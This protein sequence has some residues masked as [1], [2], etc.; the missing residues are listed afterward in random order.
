MDS[1]QECLWYEKYQEMGDKETKDV[2]IIYQF[3]STQPLVFQGEKKLLSI[4]HYWFKT[5]SSHE[6]SFQ[7]YLFNLINL[8]STLKIHPSTNFVADR[9]EPLFIMQLQAALSIA[10]P[11]CSLLPPTAK[12]MAFSIQ[13]RSLPRQSKGTLKAKASAVGQEP[14][15]VDYSSMS[16]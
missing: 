9:T 8:N 2:I 13:T 3:K 15:T 12:L 16:S 14:S 10:P 5:L 1:L 7:L 4:L 11:S 6:I